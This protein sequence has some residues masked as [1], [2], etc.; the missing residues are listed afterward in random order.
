MMKTS[1]FAIVQFK[2]MKI[3]D[4]SNL[5]SAQIDTLQCMASRAAVDNQEELSIN[6]DS[7]ARPQQIIVFCASTK[8]L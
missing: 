1:K 5:I 2:G 6:F 8:P 3:T 7:F 4:I